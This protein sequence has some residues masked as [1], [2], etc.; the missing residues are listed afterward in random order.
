M[1]IRRIIWPLYRV[2][3]LH[4]AA[5][6]LATFGTIWL[7]CNDQFY[8]SSSCGSFVW[9]YF[10]PGFL[11]GNVNSSVP[12][13]YPDSPQSPRKLP[14]VQI[15]KREK[16]VSVNMGVIS[17]YET[18]SLASNEPVEDR[19]SEHMLSNG[20]LFGVF[21]GHSGW[22]CAEDVMKRLPY[23]V[24]LSMTCGGEMD[25]NPDR[26][27]SKL[28]GEVKSFEQSLGHDLD[29]A[30]KDL[31]GKKAKELCESALKTSQVK[32]IDQQLKNAFKL[33][34]DDI[35]HEAMPNVNGHMPEEMLKG[36]SGACAITAYVQERELYIASSG[37]CRAVLGSKGSDGKWHAVSLSVDQNSLN[38]E[39]VDRLKQEHPGENH[40]V[41]NNRLLGLLQPF[42]AFGD[43]IFKWDYRLHEE[44]LN[45]IYGRN[46]VPPNKYRTPPYLTAEPVVTHRSLQPGDKFVVIATDGLWDMI[47][48]ETAVECIGG[49]VESGSLARNVDDTDHGQVNGASQLIQ[50]ALGGDDEVKVSTLLAAPKQIRRAMR[51]DIT[52]TVVYF[53]D[54]EI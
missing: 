54:A 18:N 28:L 46:L 9:Q 10:V 44:F 32:D 29:N 22:Q 25:A 45:K 36:L 52:V 17:H 11:K 27:Y 50:E 41:T 13:R 15:R 40:V 42:R 23:Y 53:K 49:L 5:G 37:D 16:V 51:D 35:V 12:G 7:G 21:D 47:S 2:R 43:V 33:L 48:S 39:E 3:R 24:A 30:A 26:V 14:N 8:F 1:P 4:A 19:N 20:V 6:V 38:H 34:D 31:F